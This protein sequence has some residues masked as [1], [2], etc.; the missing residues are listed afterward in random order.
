MSRLGWLIV[1]L[2]GFT[3]AALV[4]FFVLMRPA[5][6]LLGAAIEPV[7]GGEMVQT[8]SFLGKP[9]VLILFTPT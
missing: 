7:A 1:F 9:T 8:N 3:V 5:P 6:D 2:V 4:G